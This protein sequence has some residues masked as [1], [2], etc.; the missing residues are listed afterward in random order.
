M[1]IL[2]LSDI[3]L[4]R[5][6]FGVS[7][8][9]DLHALTAQMV[10]MAARPDVDC[11]VIAGD[12]YHHSQPNPDALNA[13][14]RFLSELADAGKP[15]LVARGNHDGEAQLAYAS[16]LLRRANVFITPAFC[17]ETT[18]VTL[19][20]AFGPVDFWLLPHI[21]PVQA[22]RCWPEEQIETYADAVARAID[23]MDLD[24][25]RRNVLVT[26]QY[27]SG[28]Q[29]SDSEERSVGG[30]DTVPAEL[31]ECFDYVALGH[32]HR[33][34][35]LKGF[36]RYAGSPMPFSFDDDGEG[37]RSATLAS[38]AEKG[39]PVEIQ[40][41]PLQPLRR[42]VRLEGTLDELTA[43]PGGDDYV[44]ALLT[45]AVRP[46]EPAN[47]LRRIWPNLLNVQ[48]LHAAVES[49]PAEDRR[50]TDTGTDPV[51]HFAAFYLERNGRAPD[52]E[53]LEVVRKILDGEDE[54]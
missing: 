30:L 38:L 9:E 10:A 21:K 6:L 33:P 16:E 42:L 15:V 4:G 53:V 34:Q 54:E 47:S 50:T 27:V 12:L 20:D 25:S 8:E 18:R 26:H 39:A 22:R 19:S 7:L 3:H 5:R 14:S 31:F 46:L 51:G 49:A 36:I 2:H 43:L 35:T 23:H 17:G 24:R 1:N 37:V 45:D 29:T 40:T 28:A 52:E 32:L 48:L 13:C 41:L 44:Q 11:V